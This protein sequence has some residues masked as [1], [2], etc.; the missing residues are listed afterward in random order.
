LEFGERKPEAFGDDVAAS[1][2]TLQQVFVATAHADGFIA[3]E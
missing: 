2:W 3:I 1:I